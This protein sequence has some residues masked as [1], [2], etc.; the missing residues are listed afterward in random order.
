MS[1]NIKVNAEEQFNQLAESIFNDKKQDEFITISF[2]GEKSHFLRFSQSKIRQNGMVHDASLNISLIYD[3][4][5]CSG[6]IP[7]TGDLNNDIISL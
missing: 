1:I 7:V 6:N 2:G 5:K 3:N 4:R